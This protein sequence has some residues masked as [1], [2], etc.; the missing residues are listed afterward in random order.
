MDASCSLALDFDAF[1]SLW[2]IGDDEDKIAWSLVHGGT[3]SDVVIVLCTSST[4]N[5]V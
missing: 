1:V 2:N 3:F 5:S 4:Q